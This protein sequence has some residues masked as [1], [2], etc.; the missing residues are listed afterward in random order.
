MF[1]KTGVA[2]I[3]AALDDLGSG[4][5]R[6]NVELR[7]FDGVLLRLKGDGKRFS[8]SLREP[9]VEGRTFIAPFAT[10]GKW[11]IVRIPFSQVR[12]FSFPL[13][14]IRLPDCSSIHR[15]ILVLRSITLAKGAFPEDCYPSLFTYTVEYSIPFPI[16]HSMEYRAGPLSSPG[17]TNPGYTRGPP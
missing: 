4:D 16:P 2:Q 17:C 9:G 10:T 15:D 1:S 5:T 13:N 8:V 14:A 7:K 3:S 11:Q 12:A 6:G